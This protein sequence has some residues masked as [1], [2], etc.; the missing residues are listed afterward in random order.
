VA[1]LIRIESKG[2]VFFQ[3]TR[4]GQNGKLFE[5]LKFRSMKV[6][7][8]KYSR[9]PDERTDARITRVG[10]FLR[11]T[12]LDEVPQLIN[13]LRGDMSLVGPRPE[14]PFI[15]AGYGPWEAMRLLVPQG[16]TGFWQ[17]SADRKHAIHQSIEYDL[18]YIHNRTLLMDV[19][20]L[21]HT[22]VYAAK[23]I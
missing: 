2:P 20:I 12:S 11:E 3:Q 7:A 14:M 8:P 9:S 23:G 18:Y 22:L 5:I 19:A 16:I 1:I 4:V 10:R 17:L 13:V 15:A 21:L 6:D